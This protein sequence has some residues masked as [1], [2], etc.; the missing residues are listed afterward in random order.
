[1]NNSIFGIR[2]MGN[3]CYIN[4]LI[5]CLRYNKDLNKYL[6]SEQFKDNLNGKERSLIESFSN[7]IVQ[8][9]NI[10]TKTI[11]RPESFIKKFDRDFNEIATN[12]QD[13]H[14]ALLFLLD[15]FHS[16]ISRNVKIRAAS[17]AIEQESSKNWK[18]FFEK[19]YSEIIRIFYGQSKTTILCSKCNNES[20]SFSPMNH[21]PVDVK[22]SL[23]ESI[24]SYFTE[25]IVEKRCEKC[26]TEENID[27]AKKFT[28]SILPQYLIVQIKRFQW[29][30]QGRLIKINGHIEVPELIDLSNYYCYDKDHIGYQL[31]GGVIHYGSP[32]FGHYISYCKNEETWLCYDDDTVNPL[33]NNKKEALKNNSYI[34][35]YKKV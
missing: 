5:H 18:L 27:H 7:I 10:E 2:N 23:R 33:T 8:T 4:S 32:T 14:E 11:I 20:N 1:M 21:I 16:S 30:P 24:D 15:K 31:Y 34:L 12:P 3:T 13:A 9:E 26:S 35:F 19:D 28:I 6:K 17:N 22:K 29:T 25:E